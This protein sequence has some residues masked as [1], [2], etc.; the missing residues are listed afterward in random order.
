MPEK[1]QLVERILTTINT[2]QK[3]ARASS[4]TLKRLEHPQ[5]ILQVSVPIRMDNGALATFQGYRVRY[6]DILGPTKGGVRFHPA[7][8]L[9]EVTALSF[10]MTLKCAL[11]GLPYGGGKGGICVNPKTLS[12]LVLE[13]LSRSYI[14]Q[15]ADF[16][17]PQQDILAPDVYTN[18]TIMGWM[19]DT[20]SKI[21][22]AHLPAALTGKPTSLGGSL[23]RSDATGKGAYYCI[24]ELEKIHRWTPQETTVAVQGFGNG[25]QHI[26]RALHADGYKVVAVSDS[27]GGIYCQEGLDIPHLIQ[28]KNTTKRL[29]AEHGA[30]PGT[31]TQATERITNEALLGLPVH[32]LV[33]AA[34][35]DQITEA[36]A[37]L[38]TAPW[39]V[40]LA[41]GPITEG[42]DAILHKAGTQVLP[43]ILANAGGVIVSYFEWV[44]NN[45]GEYW[46]ATTVYDKL[47]KTITAAFQHTHSL[48]SEH[49]VSL[50]I[51][52]YTAALQR[53]D[54][55]VLA[56][57]TQDTFG[58]SQ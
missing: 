51:A 53:I 22:R 20:Y 37:A 48:A 16:I 32:I 1:K 2:A 19:S 34:L 11:V 35:E 28:V 4:E 44:Q 23:G 50:R 9:D 26:A 43:D 33:P 7:V 40:E 52:A 21:K 25:G 41:N 24:K 42:A 15:I 18:P 3:F 29:Q 54:Q 49:Q 12:L 17:G 14:E 39:V 56:L 6:N 45:T 57:G 58:N 10:W 36:N 30:E 38:V 13:R 5:A 47:R 27:T 8:T 31:T 55:A 46:P